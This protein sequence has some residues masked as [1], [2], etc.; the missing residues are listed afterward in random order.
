ALGL[1]AKKDFTYDAGKDVYACPA[2]KELTHRFNTYELGRSL[3]Y[4]RA[5]GCAQC[6]LKARCTR[7][8]G[9]RTITRA[10][11][12]H[13]MEAMAA[14]VK[15]HPEKLRQRKGLVEHPFGTIKRWFGY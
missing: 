5:R 14:R 7:N 6:A 11:D 12:E 13:L 1:Y 2:G 4:Y 8:R 10:E 3:R 9:N 15:A